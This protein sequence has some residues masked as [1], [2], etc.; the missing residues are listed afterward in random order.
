[1]S[2]RLREF[3]LGMA[4]DLDRAKRLTAD[5]EGE[6]AQSDLSDEEKEAVLS[7]DADRIRQAAG[8]A[9]ADPISLEAF[10]PI[11]P[12]SR[13]ARKPAKR[14]PAKPARRKPARK[15]PAKKGPRKGGTAKRGTRKTPRKTARKSTRA[16]G[17]KG[18]RRRR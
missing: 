1:M 4:T 14:R 18:S 2:E 8:M 17:R 3:V 12:P 7:R 9:L 10:L 5:P 13:P 6:L 15:A 16:P 11:K